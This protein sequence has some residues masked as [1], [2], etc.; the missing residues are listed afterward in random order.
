M[1]KIT[2][3]KD[4]DGDFEISY[5]KKSVK[6]PS[7][8]VFPVQPDIASVAETDITTVLPQPVIVLY[9]HSSVH[10]ASLSEIYSLGT[11]RREDPSSERSPNESCIVVLHL[12][13]TS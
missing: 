8:L 12:I 4:E 7:K 11:H 6:D 1:G 2:N 13:V 9:W 5:L 3:Q 10:A